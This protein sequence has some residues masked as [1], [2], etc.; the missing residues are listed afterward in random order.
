MTESCAARRSRAQRRGSRRRPGPAGEF[1]GSAGTPPVAPTA[2]SRASLFH[3]YVSSHPVQRLVPPALS[4]LGGR[5][6]PAD[7]G[8]GRAGLRGGAAGDLGGGGWLPPE[9]ADRDLL[10][11]AVRGGRRVPDL[12]PARPAVWLAAGRDGGPVRRRIGGGG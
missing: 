3:R 11:G 6:H 7:H 10:R 4:V 1:P 9:R 5:G 12:P 2:C 8:G